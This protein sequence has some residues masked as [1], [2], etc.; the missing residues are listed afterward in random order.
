MPAQEKKTP[1]SIY[2]KLNKQ[3]KSFKIP[4]CL[5]L[6]LKQR[7]GG[8]CGSRRQSESSNS[9]SKTAEEN[10]TPIKVLQNQ[11]KDYGISRDRCF[12]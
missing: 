11:F 12:R 3:L 6:V 1:N 7:A 9:S 4:I 2:T 8:G 5:P 10:G